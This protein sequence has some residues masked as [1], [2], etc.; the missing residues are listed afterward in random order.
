MLQ[1]AVPPEPSIKQRIKNTFAR[2]P[3]INLQF[4]DAKAAERAILANLQEYTK[5]QA[6][7]RLTIS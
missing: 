2:F 3:H 4:Q 1:N 7:Y 5:V 6:I